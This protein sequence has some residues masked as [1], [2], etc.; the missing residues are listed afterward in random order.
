MVPLIHAA[1]HGRLTSGALW[2]QYHQDRMLLPKLIFVS[3]GVLTH[4]DLR[5]LV[6]VSA[7][8]F[9]ATFF[10]FLVLFPLLPRPTS[11]GAVSSRGECRVV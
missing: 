6:T 8:T 1:L 5:V 10:V 7:L 4:D 2:A 3:V 11:F 9:V